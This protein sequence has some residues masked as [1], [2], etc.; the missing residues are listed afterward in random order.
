MATRL[1]ILEDDHGLRASLRLVLEDDFT[2]LGAQLST[3]VI[4]ASLR[5][6]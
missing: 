3:S 6:S 2:V 4:C 1:L 5:S